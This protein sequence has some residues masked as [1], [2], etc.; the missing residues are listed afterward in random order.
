MFEPDDSD[1][2][3]PLSFLHVKTRTLCFSSGLNP[4]Q[5]TA[6]PVDF[7]SEVAFSGDVALKL[8]ERTLF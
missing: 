1:L 3:Y 6:V 2:S 4:N 8:T 7:Q 5:L